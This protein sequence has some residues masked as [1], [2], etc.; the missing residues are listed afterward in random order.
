MKIRVRSKA[1]KRAVFV[2]HFP[3]SKNMDKDNNESGVDEEFVH[4]ISSLQM[5]FMIPDLFTTFP[6]IIDLVSTK[7]SQAQLKTADICLPYLK[8]ES[9]NVEYNRNGIARLDREKHITFLRRSLETKLTHHYTGYDASRP[10]ILYWCIHGLQLLGADV[11]QYSEQLVDT[12]RWMQ[13]PEGGFGGGFGQMAHLATTYACVLALATAGD[14]N[15][16]DCINRLTMWKWLSSLKQPD[17][18]FAMAVGG[19]VDV[20]GAYC[21]ATVIYLLNL[22]LEVAPEFADRLPKG[23]NLH[24]NLAQYV[25][26][27]QTFEGG[28]SG[29]PDAEAHGAYAF[30]ALACLSILGIPHESIPEHLDVPKLITWISSRQYAPEGGFSGRTNKLVDGCYSH[31]IGGCWPLVEATLYSGESPSLTANISPIY[32]REGLIR[33]I[34]NCCQDHSKRGGLRDKPGK[35][36]DAYHTCYV[37]SGL[38]SAQHTFTY[39]RRNDNCEPW[40]ITPHVV[41]RQVFD[42]RDRLA[43]LHPVYVISQSKVEAIRSY[44]VA[45]SGF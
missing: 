20:R 15:G 27:C 42:E 17:G 21:A 22:P 41:E 45:K 35:P 18:G 39:V 2:R 33:Y 44:F 36:S 40:D 14:Q 30:C 24:T 12:A 1:T 5:E 3:R 37:L 25:R 13:H 7:T 11:S 29:R 10:W 34:L 43:T 26:R 8:A 19:E 23:T 6:P 16:Y 32:S 4:D 38:S 9:E 28:I 31:W